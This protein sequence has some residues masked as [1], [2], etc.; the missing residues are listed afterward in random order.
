MKK[1]KTGREN[2]ISNSDL[3]QK[4]KSSKIENGVFIYNEVLTVGQLATKLNISASE[5]IKTYFLKGQML[6]INSVLTDDM[7]GEI[8]LEHN[9]DVQKEEIKD[10]DD[11]ENLDFEDDPSQLIE[12][13]PVV[14]VMGHVDH[15]KTTLID[16]IRNS[17][18]VAT[19]AGGISQAIGAYQKEYN[20]KKITIIDTPGHKAFAAM[21]ARGASVTDIVI[22]IVAADDSVMPQTIEAIDHAKAAG[23][24]IIVAINKIDKPGANPEKVMTDLMSYEII[25]EK[26]G[27]S[28]IFVEVSA[29][30]GDG[31]EDLLENVLLQAE[32]L[33]LKANPNRYAIGTVLEA[34]LDK[35]EGPKATLLIQN[36]T[37]KTGDYVVV[38][39]TYGKVR[40]MNDDYNK[41]L[42]EA[43]PSTPVSIIG[44]NDVPLAGDKFVALEDERT[45]KDI[46][47][48]RRIKKELAE[49]K[50][51]VISTMDE[52][53]NKVSE[54]EL[55][56]VN[57]IVKADSTGSAE[58]IKASLENIKSEDVKINVIKS[59]AGAITESD[60]LLANASNAIIYG[61]N[62]RPDAMIKQKAKEEK[63]EIRL[64]EIIYQLLEEVEDLVK[65][66]KKA[67]ITE[68]YRGQAEVRQLIKSS[69]IGT[70][71]GCYVTDGVIPANSPIRLLREG[72]V[73]FKGNIA[74]LKR[75]KDDAKEVKQGFECGISIDGYN[76]IHEND[77]IEAYALVEK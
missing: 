3:K 75:F 74:G 46:A 6:T 55:T 33:E 57:I 61:F 24:P 71:A 22:L 72:K 34:K 18:V 27:G 35:G 4:P 21:R 41:I 7:V 5:I 62:V 15:G 2:N 13:A 42:K 64:S 26:Y 10:V 43:G 8:C 73:V 32:M 76:D 47:N 25:P 65:G 51:Q 70:I 11:I 20:G 38:G 54:G 17:N 28:N 63:V 12:R 52:L 58:A 53:F 56:Q 16:A 29:K 9:F 45:A 30:K 66:L 48:K 40:R 19:E 68:E 59:S 14:T 23:V 37:L 69:K 60:I 39:T 77:I 44:L 1:N 67:V 49:R 50:S 36:G 31:I